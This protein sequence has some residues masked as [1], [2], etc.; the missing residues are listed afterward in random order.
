MHYHMRIH[1]NRLLAI[2]L[3]LLIVCSLFL[4]S[5]CAD[6]GKWGDA[7]FY[8]SSWL[9]DYENTKEYSISDSMQLAA[10]LNA[11]NSGVTF[12][13]KIIRLAANVDMSEHIWTTAYSY[14]NF[15]MGT[16]DGGGHIISG[17]QT[18]QDVKNG[19]F[20]FN[21]SGTI[22][23]VLLHVGFANV[24]S[25]SVAIHNYGTIQNVG[26]I[27]DVG[28][29]N[30][31]TCGG[32]VCINGGKIENCYSG[33]EIKCAEAGIKGGITAKNTGTLN[34]CFWSMPDRV[35][36]DK[37]GTISNCEKISDK[38]SIDANL[39]TLAYTNGW[40]TWADDT[41][42]AFSGYPVMIFK[43][44]GDNSIPVTGVS[45]PFREKQMYVG[46]EFTIECTVYPSDASNKA[47]V[48]LTTNESV[49]TVDENGKIIAVGPGFATI[50]A[51][52][53]NGGKVANCFINVLSDKNVIKSQSIKLDNVEYRIPI[54]KTAQIRYTVYPENASVRSATF[55]VADEGVVSCSD[56]GLLTPVSA[57]STVV[58]VSAT[59]GGCSVSALV[60]VIE[61]NYSGIWDGTVATSFAGGDGTKQNPYIIENGSHLAK[62]A[63]E[64]NNGNSFEGVYFVQKIS[65]MLNN[66]TI[67]GWT[68]KLT[69][70]N[71]WVPIGVSSDRLFKGNYDGGGF[72][73]NGLYTDSSYDATGLFGYV[74]TGTI[75]NV[76]LTDS[77]IRGNEFIGGIV[78]FSASSVY[79][80][81]VAES[82]TIT[83]TK[84]VGAI[85]GYNAYKINNCRN[86]ANLEGIENLGGIVGYSDNAVIN[87]LNSGKV[88]GSVNVGGVCGKSS[89]LI[90]NCVNTVTVYGNKM[91]GGIAGY[92]ELDVVN[93]HC[94]I[95]PEATENVG[96]IVGFAKRPVGSYSLN[97]YSSC[98]NLPNRDEYLIQLS[99]DGVYTTVIGG[100]NYLDILNL[101][102]GCITS[103]TYYD[104]Q[105]NESKAIVLSSQS[106]THNK[107]VDG[108]TNLSIS[109]SQINPDMKFNF[110]ELNSNDLEDFI[111]KVNYNKLFQSSNLLNED[112][113]FVREVSAETTDLVGFSL[114][115]P[116]SIEIAADQS[117]YDVFSKTALLNYSGNSIYVYVTEY[118]SKTPDGNYVG[119]LKC[120][121]HSFENDT[122]VENR[123]LS[124]RCTF[125]YDGSYITFS[126]DFLG[127]WA[128]A[129]I[130][131]NEQI[132]PIETG[133]AEITMPI[134]EI[135]EESFDFGIIYTVVILVIVG[136][137]ALAIIVIQR[138][139]NNLLIHGSDED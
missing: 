139:K 106:K 113:I 41:Q 34:Q 61:D 58:T 29:D 91:C 9:G 46:E 22:L 90:E 79:G 75:S 8:D 134:E 125:V 84:Y 31:M 73:I 121:Y 59:D 126:S 138:S 131:E 39:N 17:L 88:V 77:V 98:G 67:D 137:A 68:T 15:F 82:V 10:F 132:V 114:K 13:Q 136:F 32:I 44:E 65:I 6:D 80:C 25:A 93:S 109:G 116:L 123:E 57:G 105:I 19:A 120:M 127:V 23:N 103:D 63:K 101:H 129:D 97:T 53:Q 27:G 130:T 14:G 3:L 102:I 69:A 66:T 28:S 51:T 12:E 70:I 36:S 108:E 81:E 40:L 119:A 18:S 78:G 83:G 124:T 76:Y 100:K 7:G 135:E 56:S 52:T 74:S 38:S 87:C 85:A 133:T 128:I 50:R 118:L 1:I 71:N 72:S 48:W 62:L 20:M 107:I 111:D 30:T 94:I 16:F 86:Y 35:S 42:N 64:V 117:V 95:F 33:A 115:I 43:D 5:V 2:S 49:A 122:I 99:S 92:S 55:K 26:V 21:N 45:F 24:D 89:Y 37:K 11:T 112:I 110:F 60:T 4:H 96:M 54:D 104:W 47:I